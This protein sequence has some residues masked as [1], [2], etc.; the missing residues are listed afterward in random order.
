MAPKLVDMKRTDADKKAEAERYKDEPY[1][2]SD[3]YGYGLTLRLDNE[4]LDKLG[5][6]GKGLTVDGTVRIVAVGVISEESSNSYNGKT[7]RNMAIQIQ[8]LAIE[9]NGEDDDPLKVL[10]NA[11]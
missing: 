10:Y 11:D 8:Q 7:R 2:S 3:D 6:D 4:Q 9:P 5:I 1:I